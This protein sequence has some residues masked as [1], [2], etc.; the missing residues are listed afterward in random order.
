MILKFI[1]AKQAKDTH[2]YKN[3]K[4]KLYKTTVAIWYNKICRDKQLTPNC[5]TIKV[6]GKNLQ[7]SILTF[8]CFN[9]HTSY[10]CIYNF[11]NFSLENFNNNTYVH[12]NDSYSLVIFQHKK[13]QWRC[14]AMNSEDGQKG[15]P[16]HIE[17]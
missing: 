8:Q 11:Q 6:N 12:A 15:C 4:E 13:Y 3:T 17:S 2:L 7:R 10:T 14:M 1:I 9:P 5:I 16:K